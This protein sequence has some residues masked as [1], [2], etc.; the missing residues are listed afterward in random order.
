M[1]TNGKKADRI[2][3]FKFKGAKAQP[4][5]SA[6]KIREYNFKKGRAKTGG[7]VKGQPTKR[8]TMLIDAVMTAARLHGRDGKGKEELVGMCF[9]I[10]KKDLGAFVSLLRMVLPLQLKVDKTTLNMNVNVNYETVDDVLKDMQE[11]GITRE[12]L[13]LLSH[14]PR[15]NGGHLEG[16]DIIDAVLEAEED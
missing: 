15:T 11:K 8:Q 6:E 16:Q 7:I 4:R 9:Y 13:L 1:K 3:A 12:K 14:I 5:G 2:R 10:I